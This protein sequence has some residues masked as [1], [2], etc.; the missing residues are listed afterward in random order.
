[1]ELENAAVE[2]G[3]VEKRHEDDTMSDLSQSE[4]T[5]EVEIK[6]QFSRN[7]G[8]T[9]YTVKQPM[10]MTSGDYIL[11]SA[12]TAITGGRDPT[13]YWEA[14]NSVGYSHEGRKE[15]TGGK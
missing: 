8:Q 14:I 15:C 9:I 5:P 2:D 4:Y 11:P 13:S 12:C 7:T 6:E 1:M 3:V 10:W